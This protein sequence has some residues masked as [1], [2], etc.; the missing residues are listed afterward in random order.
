M[1]DTMEPI[2]E[3]LDEETGMIRITLGDVHGYVSSWHLIDP[4]VN[5][6][7]ALLEGEDVPS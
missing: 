4:K 1:P 7:R 6:L 5:Q 2:I 3:Q